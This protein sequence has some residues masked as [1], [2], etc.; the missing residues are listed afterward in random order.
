MST[1]QSKRSFVAYLEFQVIDF[2]WST[3]TNIKYLAAVAY[4]FLIMTVTAFFRLSKFQSFG[5]MMDI[6]ILS[7]FTSIYVVKSLLGDQ[8][9][10]PT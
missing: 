10:N 6:Q 5:C 8:P 9:V 1:I 4:N 3:V 2:L 7:N